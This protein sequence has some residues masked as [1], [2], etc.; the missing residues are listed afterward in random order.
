MKKVYLSIINSTFHN[1]ADL[2]DSNISHSCSHFAES[3]SNSRPVYKANGLVIVTE[4][5][6]LEL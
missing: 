2:S 5:E 6:N 3:A 1:G 4:Q